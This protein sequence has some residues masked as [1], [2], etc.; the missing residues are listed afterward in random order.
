MSAVNP[1]LYA[2]EPD[3]PVEE[4]IDVLV[5]STLGE[6]RPL[7]NRDQMAGMVRHADLM[8]TARLDGR[9]V[10]VARA[11]TDYSFCTYLADL[12]VDR[13][14]QGRGI[15]RE[16]LRRTHE[17]AGLHTMLVLLAAPAAQTYYP[18]IG[19]TRHDSCWIIPRPDWSFDPDEKGDVS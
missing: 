5:R 4:F 18:Y 7:Q 2:R 8:L 11:L 1:I 10:G 12:A 3:L 19:M 16:L 15:G 9:L 6:R 13:E 17:A 14:F